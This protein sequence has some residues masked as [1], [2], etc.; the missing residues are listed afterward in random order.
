MSVA[1][2]QIATVSNIGGSGSN[3]N[4]STPNQLRSSAFAGFPRLG[5]E[6]GPY[7][8]SLDSFLFSFGEGRNLGSAKI[9]RICPEKSSFAV[10][11]SPQH[12]PCFG[13]TDLR[14]NDNFNVSAK[15]TSQCFSY[16]TEICELPS[17]SVEEYE[18]FQ[19]INKDAPLAALQSNSNPEFF[20]PLRPE[21][22]NYPTAW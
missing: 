1:S 20:P 7:Q 21:I 10:F 6:S 19:V 11:S 12:G 22:T 14:M 16:E 2:Q 15:C 4:N 9:S 8:N 13:Q 17:F 5:M 18:V 3:S